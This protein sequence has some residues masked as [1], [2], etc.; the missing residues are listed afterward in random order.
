VAAGGELGHAGAGLGEGVL[1][2]AAAPAGH[3]SGLLQLFLPGGQQPPGHLGQLADLGGEAVD[4]L[5]HGL[6]QGGVPGGEGTPRLSR[7]APAR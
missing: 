4:A 6:Q 3:G 1:G 7:R 2:A 5:P